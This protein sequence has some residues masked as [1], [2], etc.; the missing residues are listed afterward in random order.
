MPRSHALRQ[1]L[2]QV[3]LRARGRRETGAAQEAQRRTTPEAEEALNADRER[4]QALS[5]GVEARKREVE[6]QNRELEGP[7]RLS[8][9]N[10]L[11]G[12]GSAAS[13]AL[14]FLGHSGSLDELAR[15][16]EDEAED[17][18]SVPLQ[19]GSGSARPPSGSG[20]LPVQHSSR[21]V[22]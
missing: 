12:E 8:W 3:E 17:W 10:W 5:K 13:S 6:D 16:L 2:Q 20:S 4:R 1:A 18:S 15:L 9:P 7:R 22:D 11:D 21:W 14:G 19:V